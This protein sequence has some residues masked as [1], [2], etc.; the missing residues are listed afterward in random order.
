M[1]CWVE[2][3]V[4][5]LPAKAIGIQCEDDWIRFT[6]EKKDMLRYEEGH[7]APALC[8]SSAGHFLDY[9]LYDR[10]LRQRQDKETLARK[11]TKAEIQKYLPLYQELV[12]DFT[13]HTMQ[14]VHYCEYAWYD[15]TDAPDCY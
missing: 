5:R 10:E 14:D 15:G 6:E 3:H 12:P 1:S 11:L 4:L 13:E 7:F 9:I 8:S 2:Q